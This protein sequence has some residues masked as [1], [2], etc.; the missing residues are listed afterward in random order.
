[1]TQVGRFVN[2][3]LFHNIQ[4]RGAFGQG[5]ADQQSPNTGTNAPASLL[6]PANPQVAPPESPLSSSGRSSSYL[7]TIPFGAEEHPGIDHES[8]PSSG[9]IEPI[10]GIGQEVDRSHPGRPH[11]DPTPS[12]L[13]DQHRPSRLMADQHHAL[14]VGGVLLR[15]GE[16]GARP[17]SV[18]LRVHDDRAIPGT[19]SGG[20]LGGGTGSGGRGGDDQIGDLIPRSEHPAY[21][22]GAAMTPRGEGPIVVRRVRRIPVGL[23]MSHQQDGLHS[24]QLTKWGLAAAGLV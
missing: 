13:L 8:E 4:A 5:E 2:P 24:R 15:N 11:L 19:G 14:L 6:I 18:Q 17:R 20:L 22:A 9:L 3:P 21:D 7:V 16:Y 1:M 23:G 12:D 10:P